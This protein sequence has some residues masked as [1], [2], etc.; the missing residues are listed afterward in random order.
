MAQSSE[1]TN[2]AANWLLSLDENLNHVG[3][4]LESGL[5]HRL[6]FETSGI[7]VAAR[8]E[9]AFNNLKNLFR[10]RKVDK[11]YI[12]K[13]DKTPP[14][15]GYYEAYAGTRGRSSHKILVRP[16]HIKA[17]RTQKIETE[18]VSIEKQDTF[19]WVRIK[20]ITGYR[21]QIRAHLA[22]LGSPIIGDALYG[23]SSAPRLMLH[24]EKIKFLTPEGKW[25]EASDPWRG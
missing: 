4:P 13:V 9:E 10:E 19:F 23:G 7:M 2:T 11:E 24:A 1:E 22:Y 17:F 21:H 25:E 5:L 18:I 15:P 3:R 20:L 14:D 12:C 6:D 8:H 16:S